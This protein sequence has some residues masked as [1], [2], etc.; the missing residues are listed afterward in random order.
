MLPA[1][2]PLLG[3]TGYPRAWPSV[4]HASGQWVPPLVSSAGQDEDP[5][6]EAGG[7]TSHQT[8]CPGTS[9]RLSSAAPTG[10]SVKG[11]QQRPLEPLE[12][13]LVFLITEK[14]TGIHGCTCFW[15]CKHSGLVHHLHLARKWLHFS[16]KNAL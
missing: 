2:L 10:P 5:G 9:A 4:W 15:V 14:Q 16:P 3:D 8:D 12:K 6:P 1:T 13:N 11:A 7:L